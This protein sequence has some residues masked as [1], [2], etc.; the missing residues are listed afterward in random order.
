MF[1]LFSRSNEKKTDS[2]LQE[3][4]VSVECIV[5][6]ENF[7]SEGKKRP[8]GLPCGHA[9][10]C[11]CCDNITKKECP[12]CN[13]G[14]IGDIKI[15]IAMIRLIDA[16]FNKPKVT[17]EMIADKLKEV[18]A[19]KRAYMIKLE[20]E[21]K[22]KQTREEAL[23]EKEI[24]RIKLEEKSKY[25]RE[26]DRLISEERAR[27]GG[28]KLI[29]QQE[30][31]NFKKRYESEKMKHSE[32][33]VLYKSCVDEI[34]RLNEINDSSSN[35]KIKIRKLYDENMALRNENGKLREEIERKSK[36]ENEKRLREENEKIV[37]EQNAKISDDEYSECNDCRGAYKYLYMGRCQ[38]CQ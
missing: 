5:C 25:E 2:S 30:I 20:E 35:L 7:T 4:Q 24:D 3:D 16:K 15:N 17:D 34:G 14:W 12:E 32:T 26:I 29:L 37:R 31:E 8:K 21:F 6:F 36:E 19:E 27:Y 22:I 1:G 38:S 13:T 23:R 33:A 18:D 10:C 9:L 28:E 11:E